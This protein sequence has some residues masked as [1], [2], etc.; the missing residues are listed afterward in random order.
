M[1]RWLLY[2]LSKLKQLFKDSP[3][4]TLLETLVALT[5]FGMVAV[6]FLM[7][8]SVSSKALMVS[9]DRVNAESIAKSQMEDTKAQTYVAEAS[10]YPEIT[11]TSDLINQ[12][13]DI[14]VDANPLNS[15]DDGLQKI[16]ID[17]SKNGEVLFTLIG[18]KLSLEEGGQEGGYDDE[19]YI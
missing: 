12:G 10:S 5:I 19:Q 2:Y 8:L 6:I 15:P 9:Q 4:F 16:T 11:L 3:G 7:G 17:V 13:Y 1:R 14:A 18:Y